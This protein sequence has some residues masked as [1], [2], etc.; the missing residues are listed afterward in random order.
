M[1]LPYTYFSPTMTA[2]AAPKKRGYLNR[3]RKKE[4]KM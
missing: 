2:D 3:I 1:R 4:I